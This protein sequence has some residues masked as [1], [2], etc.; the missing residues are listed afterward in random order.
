MIRAAKAKF[1]VMLAD[2]FKEDTKTFYAYVKCK[3]KS[4]GTLGPLKNTSGAVVSDNKGISGIYNEFFGSV[5]TE[6]N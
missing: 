2:K 6:E 5:F 3:A 1:E 4:G